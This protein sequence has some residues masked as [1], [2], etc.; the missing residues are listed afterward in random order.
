MTKLE[1]L[2]VRID[3]KNVCVIVLLIKSRDL[4]LFENKREPY[5]FKSALV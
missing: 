2:R 3:V 4:I 5:E 1:S